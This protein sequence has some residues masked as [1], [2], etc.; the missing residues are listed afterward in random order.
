[1]Q[2]NCIFADSKEEYMKLRLKYYLFL[3]VFMLLNIAVAKAHITIG[4]VAVNESDSN[5]AYLISQEQATK[6]AA[7]R[8]C[9]I[10][11]HSPREVI[12]AT[13]TQP[14][15]SKTILRHFSKIKEYQNNAVATFLADRHL[16]I[17][18]HPDPIGYYIF[19]LKK[20]VI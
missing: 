15:F 13:D 12:I 8:L 6:K 18:L 16:L 5:C 19:T 3:L 10:Y 4:D 20:I 9:F 2:I 11:S 7:C 17:H 1:M 14:F